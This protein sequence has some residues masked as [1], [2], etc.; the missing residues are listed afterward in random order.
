MYL[1]TQRRAG[2]QPQLQSERQATSR[3]QRICRD[4]L[5]HRPDQPNSLE[6]PAL[7][8]L[9]L[10]R[11]IQHVES[12]FDTPNRQELH[13]ASCTRPY[14][15]LCGI[16]TVARRKQFARLTLAYLVNAQVDEAPLVPQSYRP[17]RKSARDQSESSLY[18]SFTGI[19]AIDRIRSRTSHPRE[20]RPKCAVTSRR[21]LPNLGAASRDD[22][23]EGLPFP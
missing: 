7:S 2:K 18:W 4:D 16:V 20:A 5:H 22:A 21:C 15:P 9:R 12:I 1:A 3:P 17:G 14:Q 23:V 19:V 13:D 10:L 11:W 6:T 8:Y